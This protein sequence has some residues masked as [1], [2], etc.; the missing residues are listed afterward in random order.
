[1]AALLSAEHVASPAHLLEHVAVADV[2]PA[3]LDALG[4]HGPPEA[5]VGHRRDHDGVARQVAPPAQVQGQQ[6]EDLVA[7]HR[8]ARP[9][10]PRAP[11]RR[12]RR[13]PGPRSAPADAHRRRRAA[14]RSVDPQ[15]S[16][17]L[18]P[19]GSTPI[20][21]TR[22]PSRS[23]TSGAVTAVAPWAQSTTI[24]RPVRSTGRRSSSERDV[25]RPAL[26]DAARSRPGARPRAAPRRSRLV[27]RRLD[28]R[29]LGVRQL[30][31]VGAEELDA[32]VREGVVGGADDR[33]RGG[34]GRRPRARPRRASAA[35]PSSPASTPALASPAASAP[36]SIGPLRRVSR[37]ISTRDPAGEAAAEGPPDREGELGRQVAVRHP[38]DPVGPEQPP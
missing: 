15:P 12:R 16:L 11:G 22:A 30:E 13:R 38:A 14:A 7:V 32:V 25:A 36:S 17:M 5:Q 24:D 4:G 6:G 20:A 27:E 35:R 28:R 9:R 19:S 8:R 21:V 37:P 26:L 33:A 18:T 23:S 34:V 3:H 10:P 1:M 31:A 2:G 29:L